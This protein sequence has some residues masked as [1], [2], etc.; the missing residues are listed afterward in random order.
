MKKYI[1]VVLI[2]CIVSGASAWMAWVYAKDAYIG[3]C[4]EAIIG[5]LMGAVPEKIAVLKKMSSE[6]ARDAMR[7]VI[8]EDVYVVASLGV[9]VHEFS[10]S[11][12]EGVCMLHNERA[13]VFSQTSKGG[14]QVIESSA[15]SYIKQ[16]HTEAVSIGSHALT[17]S[18]RNICG[19]E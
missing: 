14:F 17:P 15:A 5:H 8:A 19:G 10:D 13:E 9:D 4:R 18:T 16:I 6:G 3:E 12:I 2:T 1:I 11:A 7:K